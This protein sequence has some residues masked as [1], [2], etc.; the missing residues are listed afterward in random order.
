MNTWKW[1]VGTYYHL[2]QLSAS[3][4]WTQN[5]NKLCMDHS[6]LYVWVVRNESN[7][8]W[9]NASQ[10]LLNQNCAKTWNLKGGCSTLRLSINARDFK[11]GSEGGIKEH[12]RCCRDIVQVIMWLLP[13]QIRVVN[14]QY[15]ASWEVYNIVNCYIAVKACYISKE[16]CYI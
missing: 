13:A 4:T 6:A 11:L 12:R 14:F 16:I 7:D 8:E 9:E 2:V 1:L 3:L 15:L 5:Q 10:Q